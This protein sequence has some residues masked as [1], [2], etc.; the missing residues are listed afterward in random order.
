MPYVLQVSL[1]DLPNAPMIMQLTLEILNSWILR[2]TFLSTFISGNAHSQAIWVSIALQWKILSLGR[3]SLQ[4]VSNFHHTVIA[5]LSLCETFSIGA[6]YS[7]Q[8]Q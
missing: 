5:V 4:E 1:Y 7:N 6:L 8:F 3:L 2:L